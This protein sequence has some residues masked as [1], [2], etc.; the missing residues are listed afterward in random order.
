MLQT[1]HVLNRPKEEVHIPSNTK[2]H[3]Q[4]EQN[5]HNMPNESRAGV[6][7]TRTEIVT[8]VT[9]YTLFFGLDICTFDERPKIFKPI[10]H[11]GGP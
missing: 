10:L 7:T 4:P 9:L 11:W 2:Q 6:A 3:K 8:R 5:K 1:V